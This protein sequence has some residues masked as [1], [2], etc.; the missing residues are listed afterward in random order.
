MED[1]E[2]LVNLRIPTEQNPLVCNFI[3][4]TPHRP[5]IHSW[6]VNLS[7]EQDLWSSVPQGNNLM[8]VLLDWVVISSGKSK[9]CQF[10]VQPILSVDQNILRFDVS[11][12]DSVGVAEL[13]GQ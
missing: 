9:I 10:Y 6:V 4:N 1:L 12:D 3:K 8:G 5:D 13:K 7:P 2:D 11:V